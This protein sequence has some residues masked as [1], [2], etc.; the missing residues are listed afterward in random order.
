MRAIT[1]ILNAPGRDSAAVVRY[2]GPM[3]H[4]R[5]GTCL[6]L[7]LGFAL[8]LPSCADVAAEEAA[9]GYEHGLF[10]FTVLRLQDGDSEEANWITAAVEVETPSL[11]SLASELKVKGGAATEGTVKVRILDKLASD[12]WELVTRS[13]VAVAAARGTGIGERY[14]F[15]R[16]R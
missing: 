15:R 11:E 12:G 3:K 1:R 14:V 2:A 6:L 8:A 10:E 16:K 7:L 13:D 5:N 4:A 9:K